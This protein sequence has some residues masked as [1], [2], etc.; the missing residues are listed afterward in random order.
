VVFAMTSSCTVSRTV[1]KPGEIHSG[2][3]STKID[4]YICI[5]MGNSVAGSMRI[6]RTSRRAMACCACYP[7]SAYGMTILYIWKCSSCWHAISASVARST[8][9]AGRCLG[10]TALAIGWGSR[11]YRIDAFSGGAIGMTTGSNARSEWCRSRQRFM[12]VEGEIVTDGYKC[13]IDGTAGMT[14][15]VGT[16]RAG[17]M[18]IAGGGGVVVGTSCTR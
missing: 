7:V 10:M 17:V 13:A 18:G 16:A 15:T 1:A 5:G 8:A 4:D 12:T 6:L 3:I 9:Y 14:V 2:T 11:C